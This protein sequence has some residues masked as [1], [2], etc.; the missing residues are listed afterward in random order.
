MQLFMRIPRVAEALRYAVL[1][2]GDQSYGV[3][4]YF[5]HPLA[6]ADAIPD[7]IEDELVAA[8][9]HD[10]VEDTDRTLDDIIDNFGNNVSTIV[11][12]LTKKAGNDYEQSIDRILASKNRSAMKVKW[13]DNHVNMTG[14]KS[15]MVRA[16][17]DKLNAR[18]AKSF[19]RLSAAIGI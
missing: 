17:R 13:A 9:L 6:V 10:V 16:R 3:Y 14:D 15:G 8:M 5:V 19:I 1:A 12:L 4:P 18:Y 11:G 2:H 7:P